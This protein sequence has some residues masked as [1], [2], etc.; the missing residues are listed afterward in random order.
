MISSFCC[1]SDLRSAKVSMMTPKMRFK[2]MMMTMKKKS[3]SY[4]TLAGNS[5]S[6]LEGDL[7][8]SPMP[9]PFRSP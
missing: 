8:T 2:T 5:H 4:T 9:P 7:K 6:L 1:F 3:M